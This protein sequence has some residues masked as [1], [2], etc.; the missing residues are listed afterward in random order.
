M[1]L[2]G[3][4]GKVPWVLRGDAGRDDEGHVK[5]AV[6]SRELFGIGLVAAQEVAAMANNKWLGSSSWGGCQLTKLNRDE[7]RDFRGFTGGRL[8]WVGHDYGVLG[9]GHQP[10]VHAFQP[11]V[12][13]EGISRRLF[14][15]LD[16]LFQTPV[17]LVGGEHGVS[18]GANAWPIDR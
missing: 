11:I 7:I 2:L 5:G 15:D 12:R 8:R 1:N 4:F 6:V 14:D 3:C 17:A 18:C 9:Q 16:R 13:L 10:F